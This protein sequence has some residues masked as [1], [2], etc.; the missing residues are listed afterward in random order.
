M[1]ATDNLQGAH[2]ELRDISKSFGGTRALEGVSLEIAHG[3]IHALVGE[4]GAGKSTLGKIISGAITQDAGQVLLGGQPVHFHSP[5]E[6]IAHGVV[7]IAQ[8]LSVVPALSVAENVYLG[9]EP[10]TAGVVR[11]RALLHQYNELASRYG[12]ELSGSASAGALRTADQQ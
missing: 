4:N 1:P 5:R 10:R 9:A 11:R 2:V 3:S 12:F 7:L 6:A 8:E